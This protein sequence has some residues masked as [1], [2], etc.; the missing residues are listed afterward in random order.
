MTDRQDLQAFYP[1]GRLNRLLEGVPTGLSPAADGKPILLSLGEP[2]NQPPAFVAEELSREAAGWSRYPPPKGQDTYRDACRDWL[3]RRYGLPDD[4]L[5]A[6]QHLYPLPGTREGLF[7]SVLSMTP[8]VEAGADRPALLIPNPCY[9]VYA[10]AALAA[11]ADPVM[12]PATRAI[13][14]LP[15]YASLDP[16]DL[17]RAGLCILCSPAN[18]QGSVAN[19]G[20]LKHLITLA[21]QHDFVAAFDEC[22]SEIYSTSA[23]PGALQAAA[24]LGG[25]LDN[26]LVFHSLSKRSS[27]PGLRCGFVAGDPKLIAQLGSALQIGGAGVPLPVQAAGTRL[28]QDEAHVEVNRER[29]NRNFDVAERL[30]GSRFE[31]ARPAGGFFL[32]LNVGNGEEAA[33]ALWREAAI[34]VVPGAYMSKGEGAENP[35]DAYIRVALVYD[36]PLTEAALTR[37]CQIL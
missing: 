11:G 33:K 22:Y 4:M 28:W 32:W 15:D 19:L 6:K 14:F 29:Y 10:G 9:H 16:R 27:A 17:D 3:I 36:A 35:G 8:L 23:P 13:G 24:E 25:S 18:P 7:F 26:I 1:F 20:Q 2:Q 34:K 5:D 12:V 30:I 31:F 21:R 37:L